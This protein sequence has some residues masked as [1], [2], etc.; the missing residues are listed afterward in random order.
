MNRI[1]EG[2]QR[3]RAAGHICWRCNDAGIH[4]FR[5]DVCY[6]CQQALLRSGKIK[7]I[8]RAQRQKNHPRPTETLNAH[9]RKQREDAV[10]RR[11]LRADHIITVLAKA[12]AEAPDPPTSKAEAARRAASSA[13]MYRR[14]LPP[15]T[16][17]YD[18][19]TIVFDHFKNKERQALASQQTGDNEQQR[20]PPA[21]RPRSPSTTAMD[22]RHRA[23]GSEPETGAAVQRMRHRAGT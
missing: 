18:A 4:D 19:L 6:R 22:V 17:E 3:A 8:D 20:R 2:E 5:L 11:R 10:R 21:N 12:V 15:H 14:P 13:Y 16:V 9:D 23:R 1:E 7:P